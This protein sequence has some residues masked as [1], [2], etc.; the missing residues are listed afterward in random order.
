MTTPSTGSGSSPLTPASQGV[1]GQFV[2]HDYMAADPAAAAAFY[3]ALLDWGT[4]QWDGP[5][6]YTMWTVGGFPSGGFMQLPDEARAQGA[7]PHW[8]TYVGV[9]GVDEHVAAATA[10]GARV[11]VAPQDIPNVGRFAVMFD[12]QRATYAVYTP[13]MPM[14]PRP[15]QPGLVSW[16]E[17]ATTDAASAKEY[18]AALFGWAD[19][20]SFDMGEMG[21]YHMFGDQA[22]GSG[23]GMFDLHP[24]MEGVPPNWLPY[25]HVASVQA[26]TDRAVALGAKLIN[27]PME[28]PGGDWIAQFFDPQGGAFAVHGLAK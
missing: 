15:V 16:H 7:P 13:A 8:L 5:M 28:V 12:P 3:G 6:P 24:S 17:L 19:A 23:G 14:P 4:Q 2:W 22:A 25:F 21:L 10:Q 9:P 18:Y 26:A 27:G 1:L 20:G 11:L